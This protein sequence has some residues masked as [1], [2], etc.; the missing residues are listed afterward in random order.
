MAAPDKDPL[1]EHG[2][3][4]HFAAAW[5]QFRVEHPDQ[6]E[7]VAR[8]A[9]E[10]KGGYVL[11]AAAGELRGDVSGRY[12]RAVARGEALKPA[13]G[14]WVVVTPRPG[15]QWATIHAVLPRR[16]VLS[17]R[18][19]GQGVVEQVIATNV[20]TVLIVSSIV[21]DLNPRRIERYVALVRDGGATPV[22]VLTKADLCPDPAPPRASVEEVAPGV[23]V[24]LVSAIEGE[25][26]DELDRYLRDQHTVALVGSSGVGKSTLI[27]RWLGA[28]VQAVREVREDGRGRHTTTHR[29]LIALPRGGLVIDTPG[30][31]ELGLWEQDAGVAETFPEIEELGGRCRFSDCR[32]ESEPGCAIRRAL[33]DGRLPPE[34]FANYQKLRAELAH[35]ERTRDVRSSARHKQE[36]KKLARAINAV[37][38]PRKR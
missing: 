35:Q 15:E 2:W 24:H 32:H 28:S 13:V 23:A 7:A 12:R 33:E 37:T 30:M 16:T 10:Y 8:V 9:A 27:N 29:E 26:L 34:R 3:D 38:R 36:M 18:A 6:G 21:Q 1:E 17:R 19:A 4:P 20:D 5:E 25:G 22:V 14:D 11:Y 31:R